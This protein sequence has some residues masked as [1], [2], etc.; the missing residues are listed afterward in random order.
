MYIKWASHPSQES[1]QKNDKTREALFSRGTPLPP[2]SF[3][4]ILLNNPLPLEIRY[5]QVPLNHMPPKVIS[6]LKI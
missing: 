3:S 2:L 5:Q 4:S 1:L 6:P